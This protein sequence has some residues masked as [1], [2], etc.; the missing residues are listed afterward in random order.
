M[1]REKDNNQYV[2]REQ[3]AAH[4]FE[5]DL[6]IT[7]LNTEVNVFKKLVWS[8]LGV[9]VSGFAGTIFSILSLK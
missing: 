2:T 1:E 8:I 9:L 3:C 4:R 5:Q 7:K 6:D